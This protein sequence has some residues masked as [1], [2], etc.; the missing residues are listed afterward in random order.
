[1]VGHVGPVPNL[2][3]FHFFQLQNDVYLVCQMAKLIND[4]MTTRIMLPNTCVS[5]YTILTCLIKNCF[6]FC[7]FNLLKIITILDQSLL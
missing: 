3:Y 1:M 5:I 2:V 7:D 6:V 4:S